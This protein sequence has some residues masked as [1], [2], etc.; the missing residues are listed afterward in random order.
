MIIAVGAAAVGFFEKC[1]TGSIAGC[2]SLSV[3]GKCTL[4][5]LVGRSRADELPALDDKEIKRETPRSAR[6]NQPP[7]MFSAVAGIPGQV[8]PFAKDLFLAGDDM[9][10]PTVN[11]ALIGGVDAANRSRGVLWGRSFSAWSVEGITGIRG[12]SM[13]DEGQ[14]QLRVARQPGR[15]SLRMAAPVRCRPHTGA[16]RR[17]P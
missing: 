11:S 9:R 6:R 12:T 5:T 13:Y 10:I 16:M 3:R 14:N 1:L 15:A 17:I 2:W 4:D 7:G 8:R